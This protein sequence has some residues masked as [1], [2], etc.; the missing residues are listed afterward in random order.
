[1]D[2]GI[3]YNNYDKAARFKEEKHNYLQSNNNDLQPLTSKINQTLDQ[4]I[5]GY[6][7]SVYSAMPLKSF[8]SISSR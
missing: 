8:K 4:S 2:E 7:S 5:D 6:N 3:E 1:M